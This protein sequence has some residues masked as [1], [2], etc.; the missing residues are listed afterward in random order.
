MLRVA[1]KYRKQHIWTDRVA[2]TL[3][4]T[5]PDVVTEC[6]FGVRDADTPDLRIGRKPEN[7]E[8]IALRTH[9]TSQNVLVVDPG[10]LLRNGNT[11]SWKNGRA[12]R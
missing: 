4:S 8:N 12:A 2:T 3:Y 9:V 5:G 10:P 1:K 6:A 11:F 7:E